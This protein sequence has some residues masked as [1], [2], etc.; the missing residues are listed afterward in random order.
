MELEKYL[1][2]ELTATAHPQTLDGL[3]IVFVTIR[4]SAE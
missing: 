3:G 2:I 4:A 1:D